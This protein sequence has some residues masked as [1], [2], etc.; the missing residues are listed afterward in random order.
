MKRA[1]A[2][3]KI[4]GK[5]NEW[6]QILKKETLLFRKLKEDDQQMLLEAV[7]VFISEKDWSSKLD[8]QQRLITSYYACL[9]IFKRKT[10][11]YPSIREIDDPWPFNEWLKLNEKQFE[12]DSGKMALKE[13]RGDFIKHSQNFFD[14]PKKLKEE[15]PRIFKK[16]AAFYKLEQ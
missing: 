15:H 7:L 3:K 5:R 14:S 11:F 12:I 4:Q 9:P 6:T 16:L 10:N 2:K 1:L 13:M 8:E